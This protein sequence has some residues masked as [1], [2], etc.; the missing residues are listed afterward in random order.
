MINGSTREDNYYSYTLRFVCENTCD[1]QTIIPLI[2]VK[3]TFIFNT[4]ALPYSGSLDLYVLNTG[5]LFENISVQA[6]YNLQN[7]IS[8]TTTIT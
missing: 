3:N 4:I 8:V 2:Q 7:R 5:E 6:E 1:V